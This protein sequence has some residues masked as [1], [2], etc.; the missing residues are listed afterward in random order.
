[1]HRTWDVA[2]FKNISALNVLNK[3][4]QIAVVKSFKWGSSN[5]HWSPKKLS[6]AS[7]Y[8]VGC[9]FLGAL[10]PVRVFLHDLAGVCCCVPHRVSLFFFF[11]F[12][13]WTIT[14]WLSSLI[15]QDHPPIVSFIPLLLLVCISE[16]AKIVDPGLWKST[17]HSG[18]GLNHLIR[19]KHAVCSKGIKRRG[20]GECCLQNGCP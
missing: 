12:F 14:Y 8:I 19:W 16:I 4:A 1:M 20:S 11:L 5:F 7:Q 6:G 2:W 18:R 13:K 9:T 17:C 3:E 15:P 10:W